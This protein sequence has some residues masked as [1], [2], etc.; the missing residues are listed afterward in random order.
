MTHN[1]FGRLSE[2]FKIFGTPAKLRIFRTLADKNGIEKT[3]YYS[4]LD[5][6]VLVVIAQGWNY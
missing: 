6:R 5:S 1:E 2:L 3:I 4:L